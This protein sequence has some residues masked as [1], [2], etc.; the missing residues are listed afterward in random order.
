M[1]RLRQ[2]KN[3]EF[4]LAKKLAEQ[5]TIPLD[6]C[7]TCSAK[8]ID[9]EWEGDRVFKLEGAWHPCT[10]D[11]QRT[12]RMHYLIAS[13]PAGYFTLD[14]PK[15][16]QRDEGVK[17]AIF[18][19]LSSWENASRMGLGLLFRSTGLG[20]GKTFAAVHVGKTLIRAKQK[21]IFTDFQ[22]M[23][24]SEGRVREEM[25]SILII[26][27]VRKPWTD[28][29]SGLF[30]NR[31]E[32]VIRHRNHNALPTVIT[33][34]MTQEEMDREYPRV[35]SLLIPTTVEIDMPGGDYRNNTYAMERLALLAN[36]EV[37]PII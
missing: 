35:S 25:T 29:S 2:L 6:A 36:N 10:C 22:D 11:D 5:T 17:E 37:K 12:L 7:P 32:E 1:L 15:D 23:I 16:Y 13:I 3:E 28:K 21:V 4:E 24:Q 18:S 8:L 33:T 27:E 31:F 19:Y 9:G 34:N 26:D 30:S 20:T 14:F